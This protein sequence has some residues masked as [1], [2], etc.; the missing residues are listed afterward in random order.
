MDDLSIIM[1]LIA[2]NLFE[3][4]LVAAVVLTYTEIGPG[5]ELLADAVTAIKER[6]LDV[7]WS[8]TV[9]SIKTTI[10]Q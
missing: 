6:L 7:D 4:I 8:D 3:W 1:W 9:D 10:E 2:R 5:G